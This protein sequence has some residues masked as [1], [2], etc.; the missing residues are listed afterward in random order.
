MI[1]ELEVI[2]TMLELDNKKHPALP[3]AV[4]LYEKTLFEVNALLLRQ[5]DILQND[6]GEEAEKAVA[7]IDEK[8]ADVWNSTLERLAVITEAE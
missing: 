7:E 5:R 1:Q 4:Q 3:L 8:I 2:Q 6:E